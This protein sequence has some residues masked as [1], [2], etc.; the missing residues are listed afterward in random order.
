MK[1]YAVSLAVIAL[2]FLGLSQSRFFVNLNAGIDY[3]T[4]KYYDYNN[5]PDFFDR[6]GSEFSY[7]FDLGYKF[8]DKVRF[9][10]ESRFGNYKYGS[11]VD[12]EKKATMTLDY[13]DINPRLDF[14]MFSKG[15]FEFFLSPGLRLEYISDSS[16]ETV[17]SDGTT[18]DGNYVSGA[19]AENM[20]G[21][22]AGGI[23]KYSYN[24]HFGLTLSPEY[25]LFTKKLY[26]KNDSSMRR[27]STRLGV[28]YNF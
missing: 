14:R 1:K 18:M 9:R 24:K 19:Y 2:P 8:S 7:G 16:Q 21:L 26:S 6:D 15:K 22:I 11:W 27:F 4:N 10:I 25:T 28:E 23:L 20:S 17:K 12:S 3:T 13:F 5:Y